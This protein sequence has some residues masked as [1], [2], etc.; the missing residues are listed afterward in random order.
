MTLKPRLLQHSFS[1]I[2]QFI[3]L[4]WCF[5][6]C[7]FLSRWIV[8]SLLLTLSFSTHSLLWVFNLQVESLPLCYPEPP[9]QTGWMGKR[10]LLWPKMH[11]KSAISTISTTLKHFKPEDK[12]VY[13]NPSARRFL[14]PNAKA[15]APL[16]EGT[17]VSCEHNLRNSELYR[18]DLEFLLCPRTSCEFFKN[19]PKNSVNLVVSFFSVVDLQNENALTG[20]H[21]RR[22]KCGGVF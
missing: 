15:L 16:S 21:R 20:S 22:I 12:H 5:L 2:A 6:I 8:C 18:F 9:R 4:K 17:T 1:L 10:G 3:P 14:Q 13:A 7:F 19:S 11:H